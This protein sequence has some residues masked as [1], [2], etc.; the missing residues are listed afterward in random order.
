VI[1]RSKLNIL[2]I[3]FRFFGRIPQILYGHDITNTFIVISSTYF[4][5]ETVIFGIVISQTPEFSQYT[6]GLA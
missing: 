6:L 4:C 3:A 5:N 1:L 2:R